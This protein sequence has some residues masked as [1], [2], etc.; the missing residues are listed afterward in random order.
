MT[1]LRQ[2]PR[3]GAP[4]VDPVEL[5]RYLVQA[6]L[7][8]DPPGD[9]LRISRLSGGH[10]NL[11]FVVG[12]HEGDSASQE[13]ILR[14]PPPSAADG[15]HDVLREQRILR[16]V[17]EHFSKVPAVAASCDDERI[18]GAPFYLM[19]RLPGVVVGKR[20][21]KEIPGD[22]ETARRLSLA[23][24]DTLVELHAVDI[25]APALAAIGRPEGFVERQLSGWRRRYEAAA[26]DVDTSA[27]RAFDWLERW[28]PRDDGFALLH[29]DYK[30]DNMLFD[31]GSLELTGVLDWELA[32]LGHPLLDLG[33]MLATWTEAT[34]PQPIQLFRLAPTNAPGMLTRSELVARYASKSGRDV[35][36]WRPYYVFGLVKLAVIAQQL[37]ARYERGLSKDPR[38]AMLKHGLPMLFDWCSTQIEL[39]ELSEAS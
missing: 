39:C 35:S 17:G 19:E 38:F 14:M 22:P 29:N 36:R 28:L 37:Y 31:P 23:L 7:L 6:G 16:A 3:R 9:A 11:T 30:F 2:P 15:A 32:S 21:P 1:S 33:G 26:I 4:V 25:G 13:W 34:D 8:A 10:S 5:A 24:V 12:L 18:L 20:M 27:T